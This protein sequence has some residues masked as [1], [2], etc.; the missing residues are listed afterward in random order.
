MRNF[1]FS[2][3]FLRGKLHTRP[4]I[5]TR[6]RLHDDISD[7]N[8]TN[9]LVAVGW[10]DLVLAERMQPLSEAVSNGASLPMTILHHRIQKETKTHG[11][12]A[13]S[14]LEV[15]F[16]LVVRPTDDQ[17]TSMLVCSIEPALCVCL[18]YL[19][20]IHSSHLSLQ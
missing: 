17:L 3:A 12:N 11:L 1:F 10:T 14:K 20:Q 19:S 2:S 5:L 7:A 18:C 6:P 15:D 13:N 4:F 16:E 9:M 8:I